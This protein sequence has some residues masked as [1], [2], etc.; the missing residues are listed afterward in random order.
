MKE[1]PTTSDGA[2]RVTVDIQSI[3]TFTLRT[4]YRH[5]GPSFLMDLYE[6]A[7]TAIVLGVPLVAG[8]SLLNKAPRS[9]EHVGEWRMTANS[10]LPVSLGD[11]ARLI[12]F[13]PGEYERIAPTPMVALAPIV[14]HTGLLFS[15][16]ETE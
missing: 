16:F 2:R 5:I 13:D 10:A 12:Q 9:R 14:A 1:I 15:I 7:G 4:Y 11:S 6:A 8:V 3:G